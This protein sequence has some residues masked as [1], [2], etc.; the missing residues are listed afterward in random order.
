MEYFIKVV[1]AWR[2]NWRRQDEAG[3]S[4]RFWQ[5]LREEKKGVKASDIQV[6]MKNERRI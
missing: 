5:Y 3:R 2:R 1:L 6:L 4:H